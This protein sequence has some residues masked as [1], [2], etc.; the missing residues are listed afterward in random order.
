M[1]LRLDTVFLARTWRA[2]WRVIVMIFQI[3]ASKIPNETQG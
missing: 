1:D 3:Q 2:G